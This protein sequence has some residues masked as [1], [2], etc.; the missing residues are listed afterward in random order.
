[1]KSSY[2]FLAPGFEEIEALATVDVLRRCGME[3]YTVSILDKLQVEGAH[4][5]V[6][7]ADKTIADADISNADWL[8]M[9]GGMPGAKNLAQCEVLTSSLLSHFR[10]G[11]NIAAIC[12][13]PA[14]VLAP[15]G[16][17]DN[18]RATCYPGFESM[19]KNT[20][21]TGRAVELADNV[22]TA[23]GPANTLL[24]ALAIAGQC[25]GAE[26][27]REAADGMLYINERPPVF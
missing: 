23:N 26:K 21:M 12:A 7:N 19:A 15:L 20:V 8:I 2:L 18:K 16:I 17:L 5:I 1:M 6:V 4:G 27:A 11:G 14:V 22:I 9:P 13:S 3:I 24:F 10:K 25:V